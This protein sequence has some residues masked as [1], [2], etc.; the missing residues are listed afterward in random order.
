M[1]LVD[2]VVQAVCVGERHR[3]PGSITTAIEARHA[4]QARMEGT[5]DF[6]RPVVVAAFVKADDGNATKVGLPMGA[7]VARAP[8]SY[9]AVGQQSAVSRNVNRIGQHTAGGPCPDHATCIAVCTHPSGTVPRHAGIHTGTGG[10]AP[11]GDGSVLQQGT[12]LCFGVE[13]LSQ[14]RGV[15]LGPEIDEGQVL[16]HLV[17][18]IQ[19][20]TPVKE[21]MIGVPTLHEAFVG[22]DARR[23]LVVDSRRRDELC[24]VPWLPVQFKRIRVDLK[25]V[26]QQMNGR[27][28]SGG[29]R[30]GHS[31][32][33]AK[34]ALG[35]WTPA[36]H[37]LVVAGV[38][39]Q[40]ARPLIE[41]ADLDLDRHPTG[42]Q[43]DA[44]RRGRGR[45]GVAAVA[46][47]TDRFVAP[48]GEAAV[49]NGTGGGLAHGE[50]SGAVGIVFVLQID[51]V[52]RV[53]HEV[54]VFTDQAHAVQRN[55]TRLT[56]HSIQ[57]NVW[58]ADQ[59]HGVVIG[60]SVPLHQR[61]VVQVRQGSVRVRTSDFSNTEVVLQ[62]GVLVGAPSAPKAGIGLDA[63]DHDGLI[64][65][66]RV[67]QSI[68][69]SVGLA[70]RL[71][72]NRVLGE[73]RGRRKGTEVCP[74]TRRPVW[75]VPAHEVLGEHLDEVRPPRFNRHHVHVLPI[76]VGRRAD[77]RHRPHTE[78]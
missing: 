24:N 56:R 50:G 46:Q 29:W 33:V 21:S 64:P 75:H 40:G 1:L 59:S 25:H 68:G 44:H 9:G 35:V 51:A 36:V 53:G 37:P 69:L 66:R 4:N 42:G 58:S 52:V 74:P 65:C 62:N 41:I 5:N 43:A 61:R 13:E 32:A 7:V 70:E 54:A 73:L 14:I 2:R 31:T 76:L 77:G 22:A 78:P 20:F 38:A 45:D 39:Q 23:C 18:G 49:Q 57:P 6:A 3:I 19:R 16:A 34:G 30:G 71:P 67:G 8:A 60:L 48:A 27:G 63:D 17:H 12:G 47:T 15:H 10:I 28:R 26:A 72:P 11:T 55:G